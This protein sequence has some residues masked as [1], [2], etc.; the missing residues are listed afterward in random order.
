VRYVS[1]P[2]WRGRSA[3]EVVEVMRHEALVNLAF[4]QADAS[5]LCLYDTG[6]LGSHLASAA[7]QTHLAV[8]RDGRAG[9]SPR[10][11]GQERIP[12]AYNRPLAPP[13]P[14]AQTLSY[15][16]DLRPVRQQVASCAQEAGLHGDRAADLMLAASEVAANTLRHTADGGT[17]WVWSGPDE[18]V[19]QVQDSGNVTDPLAGRWRSPDRPSGQGLWIVNQLCDLVELRTGPGGTVVRMHMC[20]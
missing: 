6:E 11:A 1:Q 20:L 7:E 4:A 19:C 8:I 15:Q 17:L 2:L 9:P 5:I 10:Y 18:V 12:P 16:Y 3:A 14:H 13:P